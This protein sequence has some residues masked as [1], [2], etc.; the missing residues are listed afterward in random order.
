M[1]RLMIHGQLLFGCLAGVFPSLKCTVPTA[2]VVSGFYGGNCDMLNDSVWLLVT[3]IFLNREQG[4][5]GIRVTEEEQMVVG[6][7]GA[8][9]QGERG[10]SRSSPSPAYLRLTVHD[11]TGS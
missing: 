6:G 9:E 2:A 3:F 10:T 7:G 4:Y 1:T 8:I 5:Y 11:H